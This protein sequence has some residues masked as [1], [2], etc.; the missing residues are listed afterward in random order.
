ME[1][2]LALPD[3]F[4]NFIAKFYIPTYIL[5]PEGRAERLPDVPESPVLVF[6]NSKSGGQLGAQLL[7][8]YRS[9]LN[10]NQVKLSSFRKTLHFLNDYVH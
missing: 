5:V 3:E 2:G 1:V 4:E 10:K 7:L 6:I 8:T 9:L